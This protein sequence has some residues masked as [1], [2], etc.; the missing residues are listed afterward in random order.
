MQQNGEQAQTELPLGQARFGSGPG[1]AV[2]Q[3]RHAESPLHRVLQIMIPR[4]NWPVSVV[5]ADKRRDR[6]IERMVDELRI[7]VRIKLAV[8]TPNLA[9]DCAGV[10]GRHWR[11]HDL[12]SLNPARWF[13]TQ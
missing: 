9:L 5:F 6:R 4:I 13:C 7:A 12:E 3:T 2:E 8:N 11:V 10:V 1:T